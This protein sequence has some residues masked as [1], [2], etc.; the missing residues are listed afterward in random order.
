M[1]KNYVLPPLVADG[2]PLS[3]YGV[4]QLINTVNHIKSDYFDYN[5][6]KQRT[7]MVNDFAAW[8]SRY[9]LVH[10]FKNLRISV[11]VQALNGMGNLKI[12][13][14]KAGTNQTSYL[15]HTA[16]ITTS[17]QTL[18]INLNMDTSLNGF[19]VNYDDIYLIS[20][21]NDYGNSGGVTCLYMYEYV[22]S[23]PTAPT[24]PT[25]AASTVVDEDYLNNIINSIR[26]LPARPNVNVPFNGVGSP[27]D[28]NASG[29]MGWLGRRRSRYVF[30]G[31]WLIDR[32]VEITF[33]VNNQAIKVQNSGTGTTQFYDFSYD[34]VTNPN[35]I[36]VPAIGSDYYFTADFDYDNETSPAAAAFVTYAYEGDY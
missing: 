7:L 33:R 30:F 32:D 1:T 10:K 24:I 15:I 17:P 18:E 5:T 31:C 19:T 23:A 29:Y 13:A 9:V 16:T 6:L 21:R 36:T 14:R 27:G 3:A 35:G 26:N 4:N 34:F 28:Y 8:E 25:L 2:N 11:Y 20:F 22:D 12:Y